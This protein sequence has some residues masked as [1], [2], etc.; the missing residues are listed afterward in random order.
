M[1]ILIYALGNGWGHLSRCL[2]ILHQL[3]L[4]NH[5][6]TILIDSPYLSYIKQYFKGVNLIQVFAVSQVIEAFNNQ[7]DYIIVDTFAT[8]LFGELESLLPK[9][10]G[11]KYF[12]HRLIKPE[13]VAKYKS[14]CH[15]FDKIFSIE[16]DLPLSF[17]PNNIN[18]DP[19]LIKSRDS[20]ID[21]NLAYRL[22]N[23]N[24]QEEKLIIL[25]IASGYKEERLI[26]QEV[27][28]R[29]ALSDDQVR[30]ISMHKPSMVPIT[31]WVKYSRVR[32]S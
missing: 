15:N 17:F 32:D 10:Q 3:N 6:V 25:V 13:L 31:L 2:S 12:I 27:A 23:I 1:R 18:T 26:Y 29:L 28:R 22:L 14:F 9:V 30:Y 19:W 16:K 20:L 4:E 8:G 11:I 7:F 24:N 5:E 21:R